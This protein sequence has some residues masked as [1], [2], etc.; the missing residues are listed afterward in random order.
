M[1]SRVRESKM[2]QEVLIGSVNLA[3]GPF[4]GSNREIGV[5]IQNKAFAD[6]FNAE[7]LAKVKQQS[8]QL[9]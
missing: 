1:Y 3:M 7:F 6:E 9:F 5:K 8:T 4:A 2:G